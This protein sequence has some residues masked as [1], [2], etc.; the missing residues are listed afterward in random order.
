MQ[1]GSRRIR[2]SSTYKRF[3]LSFLIVLLLPVTCFVFIF[4]QNYREI[5]R[6]KII[7]QAR[8]SLEASAMELERTVEGLESFVSYNLMAESITDAVLL[9]DHSAEQIEN[10]LCAE[11]IAQPILEGISYYNPVKPDMI[12][13]ANGTF[14]LKYYYY[15]Y[16]RMDSEETLREELS[17]PENAGWKVWHMA[18]LKSG[19]SDF[20]LQYIVRTWKDECWIFFISEKKLAQIISGEH[21]VTI[22]QDSKG[23]KLY[24]FRSENEEDSLNEVR[25]DG[26]EEGYC[27]INV[28]SSN[29][30]FMLTRYIDEDFLFEEINAWQRFFFAAIMAVLLM[31]GVLIL[32]LTSVNEH[33]IRK[34]QDDWRK[35]IPGIPENM[36]GLEALAFA[37]K[38]MEEQVLLTE[39]K[40][41][42]NHLLLQMIYGRDC[43]KECFRSDMKAAGIFQK[44][45]VYRVI[46]AV[47]MEETE[48]SFNKLGI[49]LDMFPEEGYE[50]RMIEVSGVDAMIFIAGMTETADK[51]LE[52]K[53]LWI[54]DKIEQNV[55]EKIQFYVGGRCTKQSKIH[56]SYSQ[57]IASS[58]NRADKAGREESR[59]RV[60]YYQSVY[61]SSR[62]SHYPSEDLNRLYTALV[63]TDLDSVSAVT[64]RLLEY[65]KKQ[66][67]NRFVSVSMYYDILNV[68]YRAQTKLELDIESASLEVDLLEMQEPLD[69]V[70]MILRIQDQYQT[71]I[72]N[73]RSNGSMQDI[74]SKA[75]V[76]PVRKVSKKSVKKEDADRERH[77]ISNVLAFIEEN[78]YSC[79]LSVS[80]VS[81]HFKM[82]ISNLSHQFKAQTNRTILDY[83]TEKKFGYAG[84]LLLTTDY[85]VQ[86]IAFMT[87]YSQTASFIRKFKQYYGMTPVEYR[88]TGVGENTEIKERD[89]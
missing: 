46:I 44:A 30:S 4:L 54:A 8:N 6:N 24:P 36:V 34:L 47:P 51:E 13:N 27:E 82:S 39:S 65:L 59:D 29:G 74:S 62:D 70:Q 20:A 5:Y 72:D 61:K 75:S 23:V 69:P 11:L 32:V 57:A 45:E 81:D 33:P 84:E 7:D 83:I 58:Q 2:V 3:I 15:N 66:S 1:I 12:Y 55:N 85:S 49:Y 88:N 77:I 35:K 14:T 37:M 52:N 18:S 28:S 43:E 87:G 9:K 79:D 16:V 38:S 86:K 68:Y 22:L 19:E 26:D 53:L 41:K 89:E 71:Y 56:V 67:D 42:R 31:G 60:V 48:I 25:F 10:I 17:H 63:E 73:I 40:H 76:K 64:E 21:S 78:S 50:F 80:M